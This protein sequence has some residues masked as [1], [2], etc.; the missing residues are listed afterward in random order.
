MIQRTVANNFHR[1]Y[2]RSIPHFKNYVRLS[3]SPIEMIHERQL[4]KLNLILN[5]AIEKVPFYR[6]FYDGLDIYSN[7]R[8]VLK[9]LKE[10]E[11]LPIL[12]KDNIRE[13][14]GLLLSDDANKRKI[15]K[16]TSGGSTGSPITV[17]QDKHYAETSA[18]L[19]LF[20]K[21]LRKIDPYRYTVYLW[22]AHR[23]L[24]GSNNSILGKIKDFVNNVKMFNS[25]RLDLAEVE[26]FIKHIN[27]EE[28]ELI[29]AY[30]QSIYE[31]ALIAKKNNISIKPQK[32]IH[33]G[34]GKLYSHMRKEIE[35]VFHCQ[36]FDHYGG[37]EFGA[38]A[39]ECTAHDGL[40]ILADEKI[41]EVVSKD[42]IPI[43][44]QEGDVLVTTLNNYSMPLIRYKVGDRAIM[45]KYNRCSC[46][47]QYPK[48]KNIVG[49]TANNFKLKSG[50]FVSGEYLTLTFNFIPGV[51]K[52]QIRQKSL[53][54]IHILLVVNEDF[55]KRKVEQEKLNKMQNLFGQEIKVEFIYLNEI[56]LTQTGKHLFTISDIK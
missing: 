35:E 15:Y 38:L 17:Y 21:S 7:G 18:G 25:A 53:E 5:H 12:T 8:I 4:E 39:T 37:R 24:Y 33:T 44:E 41:V 32:A 16:N 22:G 27:K 47:V 40:H 30:A 23:D 2:L 11:K 51:I 55:D 19:F 54:M 10:I 49:R 36:V 26:T 14:A 48:L 43:I 20:I 28:P 52:F 45:K 13:N 6:S 1:F 50:G 31:L 3:K 29:I 56:P 42:G 46:G 34:A 9:E